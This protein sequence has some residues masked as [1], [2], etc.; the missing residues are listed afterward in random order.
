MTK[1]FGSP[2]IQ[3]DQ[4]FQGLQLNFRIFL[5]YCGGLGLPGHPKDYAPVHDMYPKT[6]ATFEGEFHRIMDLF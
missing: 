5:E 3:N 6:F 4:I 2:D 1:P